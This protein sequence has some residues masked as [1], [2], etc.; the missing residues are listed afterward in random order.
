MNFEL[1]AKQKGPDQNSDGVASRVQRQMF[2][3]EGQG[4]HEPDFTEYTKRS[5]K[6][7]AVA[8]SWDG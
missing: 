2:G 7:A 3:C 4:I 5:R 6:L 1:V 8:D